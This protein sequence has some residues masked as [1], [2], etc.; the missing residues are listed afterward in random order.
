[1]HHLAHGYVPPEL[2]SRL[3]AYSLS[4]LNASLHFDVQLELNAHVYVSAFSAEC[5]LFMYTRFVVHVPTFMSMPY[6]IQTEL[7]TCLFLYE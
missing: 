2:N 1:M 5:L 4:G 7:N 3:S 6:N